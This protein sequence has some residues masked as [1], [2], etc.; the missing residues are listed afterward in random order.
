[1]TT[2]P[3]A[4][5][6]RIRRNKPGASA[7]TAASD[8]VAE[9]AAPPPLTTEK[10]AVDVQKEI[11]A[12]RRE[13]ITGRQLRVARRLAQKKG[14]AVTSDFDAVRQLREAGLD[15]F[16]R[17]ALLELVQPDGSTTP[18]NA[19]QQQLPQTVPAEGQNLPATQ[20]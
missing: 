10:T 20:S 15:P 12:I 6:F 7:A 3:K 4:K 9:A 1:M 11:D 17:E 16:Q 18:P 5:K 13:G 14:L 8:P 19:A 2:K